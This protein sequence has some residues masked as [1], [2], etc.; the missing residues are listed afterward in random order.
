MAFF[1]NDWSSSIAVPFFERLLAHVVDQYFEVPIVP[2][3]VEEVVQVFA[4]HGHVVV[5]DAT[6]GDEHV[7]KAVQYGAWP[8][9]RGH[10]WRN[11]RLCWC[12]T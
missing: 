8:I 3:L 10:R 2:E 12:R 7:H 11:E 1:E 6:L 5:L 4:G 9:K